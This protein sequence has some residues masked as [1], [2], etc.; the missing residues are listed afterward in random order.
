MRNELV[1]SRIVG[2][3]PAVGGLQRQILLKQLGL[4]VSSVER[5][6][7]SSR[8]NGPVRF[9]VLERIVQSTGAL[10][11]RGRSAHLAKNI[12][13]VV[14]ARGGRAVYPAE[15]RPGS[16]VDVLSN[17]AR[18]PPHRHPPQ[19]PAGSAAAFQ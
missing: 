7:E 14:E 1:E 6:V 9:R 2:I 19:P 4:V 16:F 3:E 11:W 13:P 5:R 18:R 10:L 12:A 8:R 15:H 17:P